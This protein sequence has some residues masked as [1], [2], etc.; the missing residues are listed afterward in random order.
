MP[1]LL[2]SRC[3][4][5]VQISGLGTGN[6]LC[7]AQTSQTA[8]SVWLIITKLEQV[9]T[10]WNAILFQLVCGS[11]IYRSGCLFLISNCSW[12]YKPSGV[13]NRGFS[14]SVQVMG[15]SWPHRA[16]SN[17]LHLFVWV[18]LCKLFILY[19]KP[20]FSNTAETELKWNTGLRENIPLA[21]YHIQTVG[22]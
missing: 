13:C 15:K 12:N 7:Y 20:S 14:L 1:P 2:H 11:T 18:N 3:P 21:F 10:H 9:V 6:W 17:Y 22:A 16:A 5:P 19:F 4:K 8:D